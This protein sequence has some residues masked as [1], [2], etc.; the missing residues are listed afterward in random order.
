MIF[1]RV[2]SRRDLA[3]GEVDLRK[4]VGYKTKGRKSV[5]DVRNKVPE[6]PVNTCFVRDAPLSCTDEQLMALAVGEAK[7]KDWLVVEPKGKK[8]KAMKVE[9]KGRYV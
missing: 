7:V 6:S 8:P 4:H 5:R 9:R 3:T 2:M 1:N